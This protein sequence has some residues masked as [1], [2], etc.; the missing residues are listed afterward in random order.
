MKLYSNQHALNAR[1][2]RMAL[3][4][5]GLGDSIE[6]VEVDIA[7]GENRRPEFL[8]ISP[9]GQVPVLELDDGSHITDSMAICRYLEA[10]H[11]EPSL[12]GTEP[13]EIAAIEQWDRRVE[14]EVSL[15]AQYAFRHLHEFW[16]GKSEQI[17]AWGEHVKARAIERLDWLDEVLA[18]RQWIAGERFSI[19]D[20]TA[21]CAIDFW[22]ISKVRIGEREHLGRWHQQVSARPSAKA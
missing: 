20:I 18:D 9:F 2:V 7:A 5:K 14:L 15:P 12:F 10:L 11:P 8:A 3:A 16:R 4:E 6:I 19:A 13:R 21:V 22:R 1:R 17:P